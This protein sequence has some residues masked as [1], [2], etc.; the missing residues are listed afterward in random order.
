MFITPVDS[1]Q[2]RVVQIEMVLVPGCSVILTHGVE[3]TEYLPIYDLSAQLPIGMVLFDYLG[4]FATVPGGGA[5]DSGRFPGDVRHNRSASGSTWSSGRG[6]QSDLRLTRSK[7]ARQVGTGCRRVDVS[8]GRG[9]GHDT[10][11]SAFKRP[12]EPC[13]DC[14]T[15]LSFSGCG[16]FWA[17]CWFPRQPQPRHCFF[18]DQAQHQ[19]LCFF[20]PTGA[21]V[22]QCPQAWG[23]PRRWAMSEVIGVPAVGAPSRVRRRWRRRGQCGGDRRDVH[24]VGLRSASKDKRKKKKKKKKKKR[25]RTRSSS[26]SQGSSSSSTGSSS[27]GRSKTK[28]TKFRRGDH[29]RWRWGSNSYRVKPDVLP[30]AA[31]KDFKNSQNL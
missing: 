9:K 25:S 20:L 15:A 26:R 23:Q 17:Q 14:A 11:F 29:L 10:R 1:Q 18:S 6:C 24:E 2:P 13:G 19:G 4:R 3:Y 12:M 27:S 5:F 31:R 28:K 21:M 22:E 7:V 16:G 30:V 8:S